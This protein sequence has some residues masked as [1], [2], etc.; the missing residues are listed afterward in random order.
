[1][2][3]AYL[4]LQERQA[5]RGL[6]LLPDRVRDVERAGC[7]SER[8][9][10]LANAFGDWI[11]KTLGP[12]DWFVN[13]ISFRDRHPDFEVGSK[14]NESARSRYLRHN[15]NIRIFSEDPRLRDWIPDFRGRLEPGPP[16]PDKALA[17]IRDFLFDLQEAAGAP[18][19]AMIAE[20]FGRVG[21]RY[22]AHLLLAGVSQLRRDKWWEEAFQRFGRTSIS[23]FDPQRGGAFYAAKYAGKQLGAIHFVGPMPGAPFSAV[24][25]PPRVVGEQDVARSPEMTREAIRRT[26]SFPRGFSAWRNKR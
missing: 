10:A 1:V 24:V 4:E 17:E 26:D 16:V 9:R 11:A 13:P 14:T 22:H 3:E 8:R 21:G 25:H 7:D 20:E 19:R 23:P 5:R 18:I 6:G 15:E 12:W 2:N